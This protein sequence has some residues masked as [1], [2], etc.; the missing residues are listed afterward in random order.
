MAD[1]ILDLRLAVD[2]QPGIV[3]QTLDGVLPTYDLLNEL[4]NH[5]RADYPYCC[6]VLFPRTEP[7]VELKMADAYLCSDGFFTEDQDVT[8][9]LTD[10]DRYMSYVI[11]Y[12]RQRRYTVPTYIESLQQAY[13]LTGHP[14]WSVARSIPDV[15]SYTQDMDEYTSDEL[16]FSKPGPVNLALSGVR[17]MTMSRNFLYDAGNAQ[18]VSFP[19]LEELYSNATGNAGYHLAG[20]ISG[21]G[22]F[23]GSLKILG[24][25]STISYYNRYIKHYINNSLEECAGTIMTSALNLERVTLLSLKNLTGVSFSDCAKLRY[26]EALNLTKS[27][28]TL[29]Q[30]CAALTELSLPALATVSGG[31]FVYNCA[32]LKKFE[33]N[34]ETIKGGILV[35]NCSALEEL[36]ALKLTE[37]TNGTIIR[38]YT[39]VRHLHLPSLR[40]RRNGGDNGFVFGIQSD[41]EMDIYLPNL[42]ELSSHVGVNHPGPR[43]NFHLGAIVGGKFSFT[44]RYNNTNM[45][46]TVLP[47]FRSKLSIT[48]CQAMTA[49]MLRDLIANLGDNTGYPTLALTLGATNLAKLTDEDIAIATTKNYTVA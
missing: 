8:H 12:F 34:I 32:A 18:T 43:F 30:N 21:Y 35:D 46:V 9:T 27:S 16:M 10:T 3:D 40:Y 25:K 49:E 2:G 23:L 42:I 36:N 26:I 22:L 48:Q 6:G 13:A 19:D 45:T 7:D 31:T 17:K 11:Y 4:R 14:C 20:N 41:G 47:G 33:T 5:Q 44:D 29:A 24:A 15:K 38:G 1:R 37:L 28:G 39:K